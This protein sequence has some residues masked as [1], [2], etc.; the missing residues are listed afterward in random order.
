[1]V[2]G[3]IRTAIPYIAGNIVIIQDADLEYDPTEYPKLIWPIQE[4]KADVVYGSQFLGG[5]QPC[6]VFLALCGQ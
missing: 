2:D 4:G 5:P 3:A 1:V 6:A